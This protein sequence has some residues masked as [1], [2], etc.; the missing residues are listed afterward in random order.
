MKR[1]IESALHISAAIL[2]W[3][4]V[5][6]LGVLLMREAS[7]PYS[8]R[9][10]EFIVLQVAF[11][12]VMIGTVR[13][14]TIHGP[15]WQGYLLLFGGISL[16]FWLGWR[17]PVS[18]APIYSIMWI[19]LIP[20]YFSTRTGLIVLF[21]TVIGW[22]LRNRYGWDYRDAL[23][24]ALLFGT[25][26]LY[27][28]FSSLTARRS[29]Q[30]SQ[31]ARNLNR[32]LIATQHLLADAA[33]E[34][35]RTRIARDLH[36]QFGHHMTALTI[37]LQVASRLAEGDVKEKVDH[38]HELSRQLLNDVRQ[39]V[40]TL[41]EHKPLDLEATLRLMV[42][43]VPELKV[44]LDVEPGL[45]VTDVLVAE[46]VVRCVQEAITNTL[47]HARASESS[48]RL[49][50]DDQTLRLKITDNGRAARGFVPGNGLAGMRER[51]EKLNGNLTLERIPSVSIN[52]DLP[53]VA[54]P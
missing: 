15:R 40:T 26:H 51:I 45:N 35:E 20:F 14:H 24:S 49:W 13:D 21:S 31:R 4:V 5:F 11:I 38:C 17:F 34:N 25:F 47:R 19:T 27:A 39:A 18:F 33:K 43:D 50:Q 28:M 1:T 8:D 16:V 37:N 22:Y 30:A 44:T 32:D 7:P 10:P 6:G 52:V 3:C 53:L 41:R 2:T 9:M 36:D 54:L 23:M 46:A 12:L 29:E 42:N 48:I